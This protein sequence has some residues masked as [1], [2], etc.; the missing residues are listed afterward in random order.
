MTRRERGSIFIV[1]LAVL[2][3]LVAV[4]A[5]VSATQRAYSIETIQ[6][7]EREMARFMAYAAIERAKQ[8]LSPRTQG[9]EPVTQ[10]TTGLS[11]AWALVGNNGDEEFVIGNGRFRMQI[12]DMSSRIDIN[13]ATEAQLQTLPLT[14]EQV[15]SILDYREADRNPRP[16]GAKDEYYNA[17]ERPYNAK[18]AVFDTIDEL[19]QVRGITPQTLYE[20]N[21]GVSGNTLVPGINGNAPILYD[22]LG[23]NAYTA[24]TRTDGQTRVNVNAQGTNIQTLTQPPVSLPANIAAQI[25][26]RKNWTGIGEIAVLPGVQGQTLS[27]ILD[28]LTTNAQPRVRGKI[29]LNT[30]T[31]STLSSVPGLTPDVVQSILQRQAQGFATLGD[32]GTLP[33]VT[34]N[35]LQQS[36]DFFSV[37]SQ[38]FLVRI[39]GTYGSAIHAIE[40]VIEVREEIPTVISVSTL[41]FND[42][43]DRWYWQQEPTTETVLV[44]AGGNP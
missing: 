29:N 37:S 24:N 42:P 21:D 1:T 33:G 3:L 11:D 19:L 16:L 13:T 8:A 35:V 18:L 27:S 41:P 32:Y 43:T 17:L 38:S 23:V 26:S 2:S 36:V 40:A 12:I 14:P 6:R 30:A 31:E 10:G 7:T 4:L 25:A 28:N 9:I 15:D 39:L 22:V 44:D 20:V 5:A 34:G